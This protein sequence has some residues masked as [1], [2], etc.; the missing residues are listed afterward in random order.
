M[1]Q[2]VPREAFAS[3]ADRL[4]LPLVKA[5]YG[6]GSY[7]QGKENPEDVDILL[8]FENE[9]VKHFHEALQ[10]AAAFATALAPEVG[11]EPHV[12]RLTEKE[13]EETNFVQEVSAQLLWQKA[14]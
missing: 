13:C 11:E 3:I 14:L 10:Q 1:P 8:V 5:V 9:A 2:Q 7:F 4:Q 12:T 6:F